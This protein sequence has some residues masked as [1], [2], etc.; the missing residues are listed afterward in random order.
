[1]LIPRDLAPV[2]REAA[3]SVPAVTLTEPRQSGK[4]TLCRHLFPRHPYI[5][6]EAMDVRRF[7]SE[8]PRAFLAGWPMARSSAKCNGCRPCFRTCKALSTKIRPPVGGTF[9][10]AWCEC[11][12]CTS[13]TR[14]SCAGCWAFATPGRPTRLTGK[15]LRNLGPFCFWFLWQAGQAFLFGIVQSEPGTQTAVH[16]RP[17]PWPAK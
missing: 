15:Q 7:A 10:S 14:G 6:L 3:R 16:P 2:L 11:R 12:K 8:D 5:S 4:S 17:K 9:A 13:S 1:M